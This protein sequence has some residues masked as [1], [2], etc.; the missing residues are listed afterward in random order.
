MSAG[1]MFFAHK[2]EIAECNSL[3]VG[4]ASGSSIFNGFHAKTG[5]HSQDCHHNHQDCHHQDCQDWPSQGQE[6]GEEES[7]FTKVLLDPV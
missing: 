5:H 7:S 6:L 4:E 2:N 1:A 3:L